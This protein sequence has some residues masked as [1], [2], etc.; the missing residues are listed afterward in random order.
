MMRSVGTF[1]AKCFAHWQLVKSWIVPG[2]DER[3]YGR[4]QVAAPVQGH[5]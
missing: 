4:L 5:V 1:D 2:H 3:Y